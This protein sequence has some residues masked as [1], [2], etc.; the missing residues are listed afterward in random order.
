MCGAG[1]GDEET[2]A[3]TIQKIPFVLP[4]NRAPFSGDEPSAFAGMG[5]HWSDHAVPGLFVG[6]PAPTRLSGLFVGAPAPA[7]LAGKCAEPN[8]GPR[9]SSASE[10]ESQDL[11][12]VVI[13]AGGR[14]DGALVDPVEDRAVDREA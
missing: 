8:G 7:R 1:G 10:G 13:E 12:V 3:S 4:D 6:A 2:D 11:S 5:G 9:S 14:G